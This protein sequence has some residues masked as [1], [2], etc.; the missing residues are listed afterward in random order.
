VVASTANAGEAQPTIPCFGLAFVNL[1][2]STCWTVTQAAAAGSAGDRAEFARRYGPVIRAYLTARWRCT[3]NQQEVDDAAQDVFLEC[4]KQGGVLERAERGRGDS[5]RAF[6]FGV[7][8][9]VALR[10]E[11]SASRRRELCGADGI[12]LEAVP[13]DT[14]AFDR[15]WAM[16]LFREAARLQ[17]QLALSRGPDACRRVEVLRLRFHE[18]LPIRDIARRLECDAAVLHHEYAK[19]RQEFKAA[20]YEVVAFHHPGSAAEVEQEC[21]NLAARLG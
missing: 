19:A 6:L 8:R 16:A 3:T 18:N 15:A 13:D 9:N 10:V 2:E 5:F 4:F 20:L 17:E 21:A 14:R 7:A 1:P 11:Q 12:D